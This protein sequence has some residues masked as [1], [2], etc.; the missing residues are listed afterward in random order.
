VVKA[1]CRSWGKSRESFQVLRK[2]DMYTNG[3]FRDLEYQ[4]EPIAEMRS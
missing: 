2:I 1:P 3:S 4:L